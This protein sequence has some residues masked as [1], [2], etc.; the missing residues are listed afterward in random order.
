MVFEYDE[1]KGKDNSGTI[2]WLKKHERWQ[3]PK[4]IITMTA[5][6]KNLENQTT[7]WVSKL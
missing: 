1:K 2:A 3:D 6:K 7:I 5:K 4:A